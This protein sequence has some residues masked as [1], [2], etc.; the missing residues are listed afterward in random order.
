VSGGKSAPRDDPDAA[1][2]RPVLRP[3]RLRSEPTEPD[4]D[5]PQPD[6]DP[7]YDDAPEQEP[8]DDPN[9]DDDAGY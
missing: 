4:D 1:L 3:R 2:D 8:A 6:D 9:Y 7:S 5:W